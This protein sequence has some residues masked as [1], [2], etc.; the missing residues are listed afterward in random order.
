MQAGCMN[1]PLRHLVTYGDSGP[2]VH[3]HLLT[4]SF[5]RVFPTGM[6]STQTSVCIRRPLSSWL[7]LGTLDGQQLS[8]IPTL[9]VLARTL[10][11]GRRHPH[12]FH[13]AD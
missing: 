9:D 5:A 13:A 8:H 12:T 1:T 6:V 4:D 11:E 7:L 3:L 2:Q 10:G